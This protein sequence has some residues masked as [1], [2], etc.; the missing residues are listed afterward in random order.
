[1]DASRTRTLSWQDPHALARSARH[2]SGLDFL[3]AIASGELAQPPIGDVLGF[4]L[5]E[6][7]PGRVVFRCDM[8]ERHFNLIGS[9]HGGLVATLID[10][11]SGCAVYTTLARGDAWTTLNLG[12][13]YL[14]PTPGE[15]PVRCVG[16][17]VRVGRR[18]GV[19][20]A[21]LLDAE[22]R[23][24]ARGSSTCLIMRG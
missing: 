15:G 21:E 6:A 8:D 14:R 12:V 18:T 16:R 20:D 11:A 2:C 5:I 7:E 17:V 9:V 23:V 10:S 3:R 1:M 13:D 4:R 24:C 22:G 19:A